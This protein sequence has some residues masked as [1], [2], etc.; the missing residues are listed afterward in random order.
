MVYLEQWEQYNQCTHGVY[1]A[2]EAVFSWY[3]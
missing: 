1:R 3:I 2:I